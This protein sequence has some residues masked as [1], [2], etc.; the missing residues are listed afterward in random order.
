MR[1]GQPKCVC[2]PK[3]KAK[4]SRP[5]RINHYP[6]LHDGHHY[7]PH[8]SRSSNSKNSNRRNN[9]NN[10]SIRN[11]KRHQHQRNYQSLHQRNQLSSEQTKTDRTQFQNDKIISIIASSSSAWSSLNRLSNLNISHSHKKTIDAHSA[12]A[13]AVA[14]GHRNMVKSQQSTSKRH[15]LAT[16]HH[17]HSSKRLSKTNR[18]SSSPNG[19]N[20]VDT[21]PH[22]QFSSAEKEFTSK[23]YGHD[24]PYPPIDLPVSSTL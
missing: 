21:N 10:N 22:R 24:I 5:K 6:Q 12:D 18:N 19:I 16:V 23:F 1:N 4:K 13:T 20:I 17:S 14:N 15:L 2:A 3:C 11:G 7:M 8:R 9:N